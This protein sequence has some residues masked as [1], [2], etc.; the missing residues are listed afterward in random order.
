[1]GQNHLLYPLFT[2]LV[3][4][5]VPKYNARMRFLEYQI[6]M[7]Y[8]RLDADRIMT[9]PEERLKL[10]EI[11]GRCG[12]Q[13]DDLIKVVV[14]DTYKRWLRE[15]GRGTEFKRVGRKR[16][17]G[18]FMRK[19][20]QR[21]SI[22]NKSWG[23]RRITGELKKLGLRIGATTVRNIMVEDN[24]GPSPKERQGE[25]PITWKTFIE[26]HME[27]LVACDFLTKDIKTLFGS[28]RVYIF[29][30]IH[31][32]SRKVYHSFPVEHPTHNWVI[33]QCRNVSM[34]LEDE[35]L[36]CQY[37]LRDRDVIYPDK[38]MRLF[39][40]SDGIKVIKTP[41][42]APM[43]NAFAE[44]YIGKF[45]RECLNY[46]HCFH[47]SQLNYISRQWQEHYN[48]ERPH[49]GRG[50]DNNILDVDF[51]PTA[52]GRIQCKQR[53]GGILKHYYREQEQGAA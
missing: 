4:W 38:R 32:G 44:S 29:V 18:E 16:K 50:I 28:Y 20:I 23:Y 10:I 31:V 12:H 36:D 9:T 15:M 33:Q 25:P 21:I 47:V 42:R 26:A 11:G 41:V 24:L 53:L 22:Q 35:D 30:F 3:Q 1:L 52:E 17:F 8:S 14:P 43:A 2:L 7:L 37:L 48:T 19:L 49:R 39:F 40:K 51:T 13:I 45:K 5:M 34:W 6:E 46:M 27:S